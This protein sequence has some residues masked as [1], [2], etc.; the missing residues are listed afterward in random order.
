MGWTDGYIEVIGSAI[1]KN[2][3]LER[4]EWVSS[5]FIKKYTRCRNGS[6]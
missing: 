4:V 2:K 3:I 6:D 1:P 5:F